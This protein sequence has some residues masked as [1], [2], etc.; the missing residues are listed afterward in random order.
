[1]AKKWFAFIAT[2][3]FFI[4]FSNMIGYIPLPTNTEHTVD[5]FG[6]RDARRSPSTRRPRTSRSRWY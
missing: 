1:M 6:A 4:W 5:I 3:F 2:L